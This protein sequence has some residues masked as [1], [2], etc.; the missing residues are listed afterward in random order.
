MDSPSPTA[1]NNPIY[2]AGEGDDSFFESDDN[3]LVSILIISVM[4]SCV[5]ALQ[6]N[7][8]YDGLDDEI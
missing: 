4:L 1:Y 5:C 2:S 3:Y 8:I 7:P 6:T